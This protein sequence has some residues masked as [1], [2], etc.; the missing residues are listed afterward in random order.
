[1]AGATPSASF[2]R[3]RWWLLLGVLLL[4]GWLGAVLFFF[5]PVGRWCTLRHGE[6]LSPAE[7]SRGGLDLELP[8]EAADVW[9]YRHRYPD[10]VIDVDFTID[11][12]PFL[13]WGEELCRRSQPNWPGWNDGSR[14]DLYPHRHRGDQTR[15]S[16]NDG[17]GYD[18]V[19]RGA[20]TYF[21]LAYDRKARRAYYSYWSDWSD[22]FG[23]Q[24]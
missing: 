15:V 9:F 11:E 6:H 20:R 2:L 4:G 24:D 13:R 14:W 18:T 22:P 3:R 19:H 8:P 16:V 1:M 17:Y 5:G 12:E 21:T 7:A 10:H 23:L